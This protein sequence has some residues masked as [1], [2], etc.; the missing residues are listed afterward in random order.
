MALVERYMA[1]LE[2]QKPKQMSG[3]QEINRC[4]AFP[5]V[6]LQLMNPVVSHCCMSEAC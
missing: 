2:K 4:I 6:S 3:S 1:F 5:F